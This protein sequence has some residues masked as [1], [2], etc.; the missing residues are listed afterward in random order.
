MAFFR[1]V[2]LALVLA[3]VPA[4]ARGSHTSHSR[5]TTCARNARGRI[6]RSKEAKRAFQH[7]NPCPSTSKASGGC[8][9]YVVDHV[10]PLKRGGVDAPNNMQWQTVADAK[11]KDRIE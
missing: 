7:A 2:F 3:A 4:L 11:A 6:K 10:V 8:P 5:C 1:V 9:G